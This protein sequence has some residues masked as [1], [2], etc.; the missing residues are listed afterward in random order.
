MNILNVHERTLLTSAED[1]WRLIA[2]LGSK[3]DLLWPVHWP[4]MRFDRPLGL[5]A[6]GGH[7]PIGY[8]VEQYARG[9]LIRCRFTRPSGFEGY[10]EFQIEPRLGSVIFRHTLRVRTRGLATAYWLLVLRPLHDALVEDAMDRASS[11]SSCH[12]FTS[13][14][15][16]RVRF[17][18]WLMSVLSG[19]RRSAQAVASMGNPR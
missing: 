9:E 3:H 17:L 6:H 14:W 15:P 16:L 12:T 8:Y 2:N 11:Y 1:A 5:G 10:H 7:G 18:K 13:P 19:R 4:K